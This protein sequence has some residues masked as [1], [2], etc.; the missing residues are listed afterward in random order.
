[1]T[2]QQVQFM[3]TPDT[4]YEQ[5]ETRL[6]RAMVKMQTGCV[7]AASSSTARRVPTAPPGGWKFCCRSSPR[8]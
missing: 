1:M 5:I 2:L 3:D 6:A 7:A 8:R 4:Y